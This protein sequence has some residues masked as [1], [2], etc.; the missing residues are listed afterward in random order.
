MPASSAAVPLFDL[1]TS[2]LV[3][4]Q[5]AAVARPLW[6]EI[7]LVTVCFGAALF[8]ICRSSDRR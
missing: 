2:G 5:N 7:G 6:F 8:A 3:L 1:L 4:G